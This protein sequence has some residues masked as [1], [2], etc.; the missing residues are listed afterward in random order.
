[1]LSRWRGKT[2]VPREISQGSMEPCLR[3]NPTSFFFSPLR[4]RERHHLPGCRHDGRCKE[5][6]AASWVRH[7]GKLVSSHTT[8]WVTASCP[9][10][11]GESKPVALECRVGTILA[12]I[13]DMYKVTED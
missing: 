13:L 10:L 8:C 5:Q 9:A 4:G 11:P 7:V 2:I 6:T 1:M 12:S 3:V